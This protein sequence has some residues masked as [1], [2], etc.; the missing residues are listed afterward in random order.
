MGAGIS[1]TKGRGM[2]ATDTPLRALSDRGLSRRGKRRAIVAVARKLWIAA[3]RVWREQRLAHAVDRRRY[4]KKLSAMR[5]TLRTLP[6]YP[7]AERLQTLTGAGIAA[8]DDPAAGARPRARGHA[9]PDQN[10]F[11]PGLDSH[12]TCK[13][14]SL[15]LSPAALP[16]RQ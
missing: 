1:A 11:R 12:H 2:R 6:P 14:R 9:R 16:I 5:V 4:P 3:W 13:K 7:L 8:L 10:F 15:G